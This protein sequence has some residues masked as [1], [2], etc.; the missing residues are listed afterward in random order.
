MKRVDDLEHLFRQPPVDDQGEGDAYY[1]D[2]YCDEEWRVASDGANTDATLQLRFFYFRDM[3]GVAVSIRLQDVSPQRLLG[4]KNDHDPAHYA[5]YLRE[6]ARRVRGHMEAAGVLPRKWLGMAVDIEGA[7]YARWAHRE[8]RMPDEAHASE[9]LQRSVDK[10]FGPGESPRVLVCPQAS[11]P[12]LC[13]LMTH[14]AMAI[15]SLYRRRVEAMQRLYAGEGVAPAQTPGL[16]KGRTFSRRMSMEGDALHREGDSQLGKVAG[17]AGGLKRRGVM[18]IVTSHLDR[19]QAEHHD[20]DA[21]S[22]EAIAK[23]VTGKGLGRDNKDR[24]AALRELPG[25]A[26]EDLRRSIQQ[27]KDCF[28]ASARLA[29][30]MSRLRWQRRW[31]D[32]GYE[33][34]ED[35]GRAELSMERF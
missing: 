13:H 19:R 3:G 1:R 26:G 16:A 21:K 6:A 9:A 12:G 22:A 29:S 32:M 18:A 5:W 28:D 30:R 7:D 17:Q 2:A 34:S 35:L 25:R 10:E 24:Y 31:R 4:K 8:V 14:N 33:M 23:A 20:V 11:D 27:A 15:D